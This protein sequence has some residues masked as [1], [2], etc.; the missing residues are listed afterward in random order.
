M[1]SRLLA[2][3]EDSVALIQTA[4]RNHLPVDPNH[5]VLDEVGDDIARF[6]VPTSQD[7]PSIEAVIDEI[8][9]E[10]WYRDQIVDRRTFEARQA[11]TGKFRAALLELSSQAPR[12]R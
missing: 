4:G 3:N 8:I 9:A 2:T 6:P 5:H 1:A 7:R 11:S 10:D 12:S